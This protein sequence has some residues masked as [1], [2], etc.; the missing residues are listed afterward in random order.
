[1]LREVL[2]E[3]NQVIF[4]VVVFLFSFSFLIFLWLREL[5]FTEY[6]GEKRSPQ[7]AGFPR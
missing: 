2:F 6:V 4:V 5:R 3:V 1:M 7:C